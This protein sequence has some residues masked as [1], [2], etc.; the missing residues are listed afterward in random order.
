MAPSLLE[1]N[2]ISLR[3][4]WWT[5]FN[6]ATNIFC[7]FLDIFVGTKCRI[8]VSKKLTIIDISLTIVVFIISS[9][10]RTALVRGSCWKKLFRLLIQVPF[11]RTRVCVVFYKLNPFF[12][13]FF[14]F[15]SRYW[16]VL[17]V[18]CCN[19]AAEFKNKAKLWTKKW[20]MNWQ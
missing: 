15:F 20:K 4:R 6:I 5:Q 11:C 8:F 18:S 12:S 16:Q 19:F 17:A 13:I 1:R 9:L 10:S 3:S 2:N 7:L 14:A